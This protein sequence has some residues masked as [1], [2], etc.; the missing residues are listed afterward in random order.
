MRHRAFLLS[1]WI[2]TVCG[3]GPSTRGESQAVSPA[4]EP[5][6]EFLLTS[7]ATDFHAHRPPD[8]VRF[9]D[10]RV[11]HVAAPDGE[12]QYMLCGQFLPAQEEGGAEWI[13]FVTIKTS[14]YEQWLGATGYC[15]G[16][17]VVW[18]GGGDLSASLLSRLD[19][20]RQG[21]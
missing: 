17:E 5:V 16:P 2:L 6:V 3:P 1:A 8:P 13:P 10:V 7:A 15:Q 21:G 20:L 9:R 11:G 18:D 19:S 14:G 12:P 4:L